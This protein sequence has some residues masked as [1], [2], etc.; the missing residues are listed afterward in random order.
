MDI[1]VHGCFGRISFSTFLFL[2]F[3][4]VSFDW[5]CFLSLDNFPVIFLFFSSFLFRFIIII[6]H[7]CF[8]S[9]YYLSYLEG[10]A[11]LP[12]FLFSFV[13]FAVECLHLTP[14]SFH[15][16]RRRRRLFVHV[17]L[18]S[19]FLFQVTARNS[20]VPSSLLS[21]FFPL[22]VSAPPSFHFHFSPVVTFIGGKERKGKE[23]G[24]KGTQKRNRGVS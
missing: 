23:K 4:P 12:S 15:R 1:C 3:L 20:E 14:Y 10:S 17:L 2:L 6:Y 24:G 21:L 5:V 22:F 18:F 16:R 9:S 8:S 11:T 19:S 13:L 7:Y